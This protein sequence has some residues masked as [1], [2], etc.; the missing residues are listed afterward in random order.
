LETAGLYFTD[1]GVD[2][3]TFMHDSWLF[4]N[5]N[6]LDAIFAAE[7]EFRET[8]PQWVRD[9]ITSE[10]KLTTIIESTPVFPKLPAEI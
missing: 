6:P 9:F 5:L 2:F 4:C 3:E 1:W 10:P 7:R 8:C